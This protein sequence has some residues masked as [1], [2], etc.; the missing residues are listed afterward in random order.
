MIVA[1]A[2]G[3][4][5]RWAVIGDASAAISGDGTDVEDYLRSVG[6]PVQAALELS[7]DTPITPALAAGLAAP[8]QLDFDGDAL[9]AALI[10]GLG[11]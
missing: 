7:R 10:E 4:P 8:V 6:L 5:A 3:V 11:Y 2:Y 9:A 1:H